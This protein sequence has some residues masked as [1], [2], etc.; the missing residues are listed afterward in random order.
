MKRLNSAC[1]DSPRRHVYTKFTSA[2]DQTQPTALDPIKGSSA[3]SLRETVSSF[4][5]PQRQREAAPQRQLDPSRGDQMQIIDASNG[6][7][8]SNQT[9]RHPMASFLVRF[10]A[11]GWKSRSATERTRSRRKSTSRHAQEIA[12]H[13]I[14]FMGQ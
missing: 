9:H 12:P 1:H 11:P 5:S 2:R 3:L 4:L 6:P 7:W 10:I 8:R 14:A 13:S